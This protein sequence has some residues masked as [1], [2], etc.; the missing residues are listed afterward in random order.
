MEEV[1]KDIE[2]YEGLYKISNYGNVKSYKIYKEGRL[3]KPMKDKD[4]YL[5]IGIRDKNG[6][7]KFYRI[8]RLVAQAF[9]PN[10]EN[11]S[12][13]NH[14]DC[15]PSNNA[16]DNLEWCTIEYNSKYRF[17]HGRACHKGEKGA[18]ATLTNQQASEIREKWNTGQYKRKDLAIIYNVTVKVIDSII[19]N[20]NY[21]DESY[22]KLYDGSQNY[23]GE[24]SSHAKLNEEQ[25]RLI[26]KIY[27]EDKKIS[28][29]QLGEMFNVS[30]KTIEGIVNRRKWKHVI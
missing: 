27:K 12:E 30:R 2:G 10:P 24:N 14:K 26:R 29:K 19:N 4:G 13:I 11:Y 5:Q 17:S 6:N 23:T 22:I 16:V 3:M 7:R 8:H 28:Y 9:I 18:R 1:W 21:I 15:D 25:V 20:R